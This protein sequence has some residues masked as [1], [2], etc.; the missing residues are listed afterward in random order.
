[1][2]QKGELR[3]VFVDSWQTHLS[4]PSK[5]EKKQRYD[6]KT[7][8]FRAECVLSEDKTLKVNIEHWQGNFSACFVKTNFWAKSPFKTKEECKR[9]NVLSDRAV[10][11]S[12][13]DGETLLQGAATKFPCA[14]SVP[15]RSTGSLVNFS[16]QVQRFNDSILLV[17]VLAL[18]IK[19]LSLNGQ[20][21]YPSWYPSWFPLFYVVRRRRN[22]EY[23]G[24]TYDSL[25]NEW[26]NPKVYCDSPRVG[27]IILMPLSIICPNTRR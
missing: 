19:V 5:H 2:K 15:F 17:Y 6:L 21:R 24:T 11:P 3:L 25:S 18:G 10:V 20:F 7:S 9:G 8:R 22:G 23:F 12:F 26:T 1:M 16:W 4:S 13:T 14:P 27:N